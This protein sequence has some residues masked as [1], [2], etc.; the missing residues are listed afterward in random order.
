M[1]TVILGLAS[2]GG[3]MQLIRLACAG[4]RD[5]ETLNGRKGPVTA[6]KFLNIVNRWALPCVCTHELKEAMHRFIENPSMHT[7][8]D[9]DAAYKAKMAAD[10]KMDLHS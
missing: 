10:F 2:L 6:G 4:F 3:S 1:L 9:L 5:L 8:A 7:L